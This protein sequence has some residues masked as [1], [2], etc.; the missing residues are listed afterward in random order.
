MLWQYIVTIVMPI[1]HKLSERERERERERVRVRVSFV[2]FFH[3]YCQKHDGHD[4]KVDIVL[5]PRCIIR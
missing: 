2:L 3:R 1:K 4:A 5:L